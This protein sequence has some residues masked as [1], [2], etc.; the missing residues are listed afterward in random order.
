[1]LTVCLIPTLC[2]HVSLGV[3]TEML[4]A[5]LIPTECQQSCSCIEM[6]TILS[7]TDIISSLTRV[8]GGG[9]V[10]VGPVSY[11]HLTLP[12]IDDV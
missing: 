8:G 9:A 3:Y 10:G 6:L 4:T 11:T 7:D 1:M 5:C 12:T 2:Q